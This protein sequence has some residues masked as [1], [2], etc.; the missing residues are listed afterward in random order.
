MYVNPL[1]P[2]KAV[3][4]QFAERISPRQSPLRL[5]ILRLRLSTHGDQ[6]LDTLPGLMYSAGASPRVSVGESVSLDH[7]HLLW[8]LRIRG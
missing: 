1:I 8:F 2:H 4:F 7:E 3:S 6:C 5:F